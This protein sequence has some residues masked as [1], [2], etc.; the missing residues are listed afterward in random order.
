M[1]QA[2]ERQRRKENFQTMGRLNLL[3]SEAKRNETKES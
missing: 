1:E 3:E 2:K